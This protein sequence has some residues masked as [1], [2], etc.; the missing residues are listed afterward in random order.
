[1]DVT[2][3]GFYSCLWPL[4]SRYSDVA[5]WGQLALQDEM[6]GEMQ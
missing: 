1:M 6:S 5:L 3:E 4:S 2:L